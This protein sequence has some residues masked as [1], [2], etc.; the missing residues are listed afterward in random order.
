MAYRESDA[1]DNAG[2][3]KARHPC[4][5]EL[6][7]GVAVRRPEPGY[8]V[9]GRLD[10]ESDTQECEERPNHKLHPSLVHVSTVR[11]PRPEWS[12]RDVP[13]PLGCGRH[14]N[15]PL[16]RVD[17]VID[18]SV[19]DRVELVALRLNNLGRRHLNTEVGVPVPVGRPAWRRAEADQSP[20]RSRVQ[21]TA[22]GL[23]RFAVA[24]DEETKAEVV[25]P[26][27]RP[28]VG[29]AQPEVAA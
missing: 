2:C 20:R 15:V 6:V 21:A 9:Y 22:E 8:K 26:K 14:T 12:V 28:T 27:E 23:H 1:E 3:N 17:D 16:N 25:V 18:Q 10:A 19:T 11:S 5:G 29:V 4:P 24:G 7:L 13:L